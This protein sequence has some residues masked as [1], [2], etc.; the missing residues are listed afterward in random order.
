[1]PSRRNVWE[2]I[3][4]WADSNPQRPAL[5]TR[6]ATA[7]YG[8]LRNLVAD[9]SQAVQ[10]RTRVPLSPRSDP[11]SIAAVLGVWAAQGSVVL[12]H[13]H[14]T[15]TQTAD[16]ISRSRAQI[17]GP[18]AA[19]HMHENRSSHGYFH[20][21]EL[22]VGLTSGTSGSPKLFARS[23]A[24]WLATFRRSDHLFTIS[25]AEVVAVPGAIDHSHFL[26]GLVHS[27]ARGATVD[28]RGA[29]DT[30]W[31]NVSVLYSVPTLAATITR[32]TPTLSR[33]KT[34]L[35]SGAAWA[36]RERHAFRQALPPKA[37]IYNFYGAGELSFVAAQHLDD[38]DDVGPPFP[39]VTV[40]IKGADGSI[41]PAGKP[42][43]IEVQSDMLFSGYLDDDG[44]VVPATRWVSVGDTG[45][46][47]GNGNLHL[48]GRSSR[49]FTRGALNVEPEAI[50]RVLNEHPTV[51]AAACV[52]RP[53]ARWGTVPVAF[54]Q[55]NGTSVATDLN[56]WCQER[57]DVVHRPVSVRIV[58]ELPLTHRGKVDYAQL[59]QLAAQDEP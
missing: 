23:H 55:S 5:V 41:N 34:V 7:T 6:T 44:H 17:D 8:E 24:S 33:L 31:N 20:H 32:N 28:L 15:A 12:L 57:L 27:L 58:S 49:M 40:R 50:E 1:M 10:P 47:D 22:F 42:G 36:P 39:G 3:E 43:T 35:S 4:R 51:T 56:R 48:T 46:I 18:H 45:F 14:L 53:D 16:V 54:A 52:P 21:D 29:D 13:R 25:P 26:Y 19:I 9:Y 11:F 37:T 2:L 38:A 59:E 30:E